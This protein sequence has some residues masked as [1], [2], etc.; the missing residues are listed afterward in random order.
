MARFAAARD[1]LNEER[2]DLADDDDNIQALID[3]GF[4]TKA[5]F[6][7][8]LPNCEPHVREGILRGLHEQ[9]GSLD[10]GVL[11]AYLKEECGI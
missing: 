11:L 4:K 6:L 3:A 7:K 1:F 5:K 10:Y 2:L 8:T 9:M